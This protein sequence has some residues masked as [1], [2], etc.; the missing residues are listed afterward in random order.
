MEHGD[1]AT[2][3]SLYDELI[4]KGLTPCEHTL[5]TLFKWSISQPDNQDKLLQI[6]LYMRDNQIY[7]RYSLA[8][9]IKTWFERYR[10]LETVIE[11]TMITIKKKP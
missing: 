10:R 3:W 9:T 2:A 4:G 5:D 1:A 8:R 6:L 7:P 11:I